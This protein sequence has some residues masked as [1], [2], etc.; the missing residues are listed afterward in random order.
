MRNRGY[1]R[2]DHLTVGLVALGLAGVGPYACALALGD[3][4][5]HTVGFEIAFAVA[6]GLYAVAMWLVLREEHSSPSA[7]V[8]MACFAVLFHALLVF[9]PPT[10]SDDAYRYVWDGRVQAQGIS[11]YAHPPEAPELR[12]LRDDEVWP[13]INRKASVTVYPA[14]AE[15]VYA[16][17]WR[18]WPDSIR[19]TQAVMSAGALLGGLVLL[20]LLRA[21]GRPAHWVLI[22]WWSPLLAFETAHAAHVD[23]LVLPLL[24]GAW[25]AR[26][27][28]RDVLTGVLLGAATSLKLYPAL[29]LPV[30]WR[31]RDDV[32]RTLPGWGMPLAF[33]GTLA[34]TYMPYLA[35]GP[36]VIGFLPLYLQERFNMGL[37]A[38]T[39]WMVE[40][41]GGHPQTV[42]NGTLLAAWAAISTVFVLRP[43]TDAEAAIRR[44]IWPIGA[45][46]LLTQN[47]FP[48]YMLW[49]VP[50]LALYVGRRGPV[51]WAG[52]FLFSGLIA[53]AYTFFVDW[54]PVPWALAAQFLPLYA[55]L[56]WDAWQALGRWR[57]ASSA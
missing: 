14:G 15:L 7:V 16:L 5:R 2:P 49:L 26:A 31:P 56:V 23:G 4:R 51:A 17:L 35:D 6:F 29:L 50:L 11:P 33:A 30:L 48:W 32:G 39:T 19:W 18:I 3:L 24:V 44:C 10:L 37:A 43:T 55:A 45:F 54:R 28:R 1:L 27:R 38:G 46:T 40:A 52:W 36:A 9:T 34:L 8:V 25:L 20:A 12:F 41:L 13:S 53:L 21:L 22:Y 57:V 42:V 47:L